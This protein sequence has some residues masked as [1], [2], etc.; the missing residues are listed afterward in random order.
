MV[1]LS[2]LMRGRLLLLLGTLRSP[3]APGG[4]WDA[5]AVVL[6]LLHPLLLTAPRLS[7]TFSSGGAVAS[8]VDTLPGLDKLPARLPARETRLVRFRET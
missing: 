2:D 7:P 6:E 1:I 3:T 8:M 5:M 4:N